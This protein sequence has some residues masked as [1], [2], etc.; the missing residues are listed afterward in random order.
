MSVNATVI[1]SDDALSE[2]PTWIERGAAGTACCVAVVV[3]RAD[4][5]T[6]MALALHGLP[7]KPP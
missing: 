1:E 4:D 7:R 6:G 2:P 5:G 3:E